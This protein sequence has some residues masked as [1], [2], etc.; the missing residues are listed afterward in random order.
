MS[1]SICGDVNVDV[2]NCRIFDH[3]TLS[4][5]TT[6]SLDSRHAQRMSYLLLAQDVDDFLQV[7]LDHRRLPPNDKMLGLK[8]G[9]F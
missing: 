7:V 8:S 2:I 3:T 5:S 6:L 1:F 9:E 4:H